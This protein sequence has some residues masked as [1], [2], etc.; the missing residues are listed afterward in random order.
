MT[1]EFLHPTRNTRI[2]ISFSRSLR[3]WSTASSRSRRSDQYRNDRTIP[4]ERPATVA[5]P[6]G[7]PRD[8]SDKKFTAHRSFRHPHVREWLDDIKDGEPGFFGGVQMINL[9]SEVDE[10]MQPDLRA[11]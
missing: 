4:R 3:R 7:Q 2:S 1:I 5:D 9:G 6:T 11:S 8:P 10:R